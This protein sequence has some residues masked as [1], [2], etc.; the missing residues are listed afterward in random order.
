MIIVNYHYK[1][2]VEI[3]FFAATPIFEQFLA[4]K[5]KFIYS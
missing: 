5:K 3:D 1:N 2:F 4:L